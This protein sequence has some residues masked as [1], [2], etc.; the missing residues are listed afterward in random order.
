[1]ASKQQKFFETLGPI[2]RNEYLSRDKW[3]LPSVCL[4][5]AALESGYNLN[6]PTLFGIKARHGQKSKVLTTSE[7]YNNNKVVID[8]A[9]AEYPDVASSVAAY[10]DLITSVSYYKDMINN[11]SYIS[12][13]N[14]INNNGD[15]NNKDGLAMYATDP[16][17]EKKIINIIEKNNLTVW[18]S[19]EETTISEDE[20]VY[21]VKAGDTLS[22]VAQYYNTTVEDI[23]AE[24]NIKNVDLIKDGQKLII[25]RSYQ[26]EV[27]ASALNVRKG[28]GLKEQIC[29][30]VSQGDVLRITK[31]KDGW[32]LSQ[33]GW[34]NLK[35]TRKI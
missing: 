15:D 35:Y 30:L 14:G 32:G 27:T 34:V 10:Y 3:V 1:M 11:T 26:V 24:N 33:K 22:K 16:E 31:E 2:A 8:A 5:Q 20:N 25:P 23:A 12:A 13:V 29:G 9:F 6:A 19:R 17:Y 4:A 21:I 18:D 7:Y 28:I